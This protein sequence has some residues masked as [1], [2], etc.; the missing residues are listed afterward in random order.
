VNTT[1]PVYFN[2]SESADP[3][4]TINSY[5]WDFG[6]GTNATDLVLVTQ[7]YVSQGTYTV[8]LTVTDNDNKTASA[9][10]TVIVQEV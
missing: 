7:T 8:T 5:F 4:G 2:A 10:T 9:A 6:D 1:E 3:D